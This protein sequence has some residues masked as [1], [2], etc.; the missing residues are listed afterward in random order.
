MLLLLLVLLIKP[1]LLEI[2]NDLLRLSADLHFLF[3][4]ITNG[5]TSLYQKV[6]FI[7]RF[8]RALALFFNKLVINCERSL[9]LQ[10]FH[11][12]IVEQHENVYGGPRLEKEILL[13]LA[14][15]NAVSATICCSSPQARAVYKCAENLDV[16]L[17]NLLVLDL[18]LPLRDLT[19]G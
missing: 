12:H 17:V 6:V 13:L 11:N 19:R 8:V 18:L 4:L 2:R 10:P 7:G 3:D 9:R 16:F 14:L 5:N 15:L 1:R